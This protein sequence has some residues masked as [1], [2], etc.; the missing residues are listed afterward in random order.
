MGAF[1]G[2][3]CIRVRD[4]FE[5]LGALFSNLRGISKYDSVVRGLVLRYATGTTTNTSKHALNWVPSGK[6]DRRG[7]R[8]EKLQN[9]PEAFL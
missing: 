4:A 6:A 9:W 5:S 1:Q 2:I 7:L 8:R 3:E